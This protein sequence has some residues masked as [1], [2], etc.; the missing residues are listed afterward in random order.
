MDSQPLQVPLAGAPHTSALPGALQ[1]NPCASDPLP[2]DGFQA[3]E[4]HRLRVGAYRVVYV[5]ED[6]LIILI[7][8]DRSSA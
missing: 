4:Y 8:V 6:D 1:R 3:G 7:R 2:V 5:V